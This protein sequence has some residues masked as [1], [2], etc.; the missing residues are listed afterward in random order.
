[1]QVAKTILEQLGGNR[2]L[3]MTG[4]RTLVT[5]QTLGVH[6]LQFDLPRGLSPVSRVVVRLMPSDLYEMDFYAGRGI[7]CR[8]LS[9]SDNV[10]ADQL[11]ATFTAATGLDTS[12]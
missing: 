2:F 5:G 9:T 1:M 12:L 7:H 10:Y 8:K 4:A 6:W 3:A 11:R